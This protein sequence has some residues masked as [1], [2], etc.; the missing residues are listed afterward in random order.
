MWNECR[1]AGDQDLWVGYG[2]STGAMSSHLFLEKG[3]AVK[4]CQP[5][6][7]YTIHYYTMYIHTL[8]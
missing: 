5:E 6:F 7:N 2:S 1:F 8:T 4:I 3:F